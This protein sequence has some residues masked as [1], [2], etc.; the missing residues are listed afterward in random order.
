[1]DS[2]DGRGDSYHGRRLHRAGD[3]SGP[4]RY[5]GQS[6]AAMAVLRLSAAHDG[7][8]VPVADR[9]FPGQPSRAGP[10]RR[11]HDG[12]LVRRECHRQLP[13]RHTGKPA[14]RFKHS[15]VL[16][17]RREFARRRGIAALDYATTEIP[18]AW[19]RLTRLAVF[20]VSNSAAII[21]EDRKIKG[22]GYASTYGVPNESYPIN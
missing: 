11:G 10:S 6:R 16:V 9:P 12:H 8:T 19:Q 15:L 21:V 3:R 1:M 2:Q 20:S 18:Y 7:R 22:L 13:G 14:G 5:P 4:R 17:S